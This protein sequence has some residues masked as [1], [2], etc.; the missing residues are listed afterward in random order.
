MS[1]YL[2]I[3]AMFQAGIENRIKAARNAIKVEDTV[4]ALQACVDGS[5]KLS[6]EQIAAARI[7]LAKVLPDLRAIE[8]TDSEPKQRTREQLIERLA[9][10]H[11]GT[12]GAD[13]RIPAPGTAAPH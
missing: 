12:T 2:P 5:E 3:D 9:K 4:R 1:D 11:G 7:L 8:H 13:E 6:K 10:L